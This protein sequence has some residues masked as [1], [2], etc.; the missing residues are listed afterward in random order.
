MNASI[1]VYDAD[2]L[3]LEVI[4]FPKTDDN[5]HAFYTLAFGG[6][7]FGRDLSL[8]CDPACAEEMVGKLRAAAAVI[9]RAYVAVTAPA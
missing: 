6:S 1:N 5:P 7:A 8:F 9:E 3:T 4:E 2:T